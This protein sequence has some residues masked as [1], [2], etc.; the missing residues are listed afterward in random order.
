MFKIGTVT[1][2]AA[3]A[4]AA[5]STSASADTGPARDGAV[6]TS[7]VSVQQGP[8]AGCPVGAVCLYKGSTWESGVDKMFW[9]YGAHNLSNVYGSRILFNNQVADGG[10]PALATECRQYNG[11]SCDSD[12]VDMYAYRTLD[13]GPINSVKLYL[14]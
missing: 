8:W 7:S 9:S 11:G 13:F 12:P 3:V 10:R 4:L 14:G 1:V 2:M 5:F 6:Q